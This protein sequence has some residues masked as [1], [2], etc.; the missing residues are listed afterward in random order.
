MRCHIIRS[1]SQEKEREKDVVAT[2]L[3]PN[4]NTG[5]EHV[6]KKCISAVKNSTHTTHDSVRDGESM[7]SQ[8]P[9]KG[10]TQRDSGKEQQRS[11]YRS[12]AL[13]PERVDPLIPKLGA[14]EP[15]GI[16]SFNSVNTTYPDS[17]LLLIREA[18][19]AKP[20]EQMDR[21]RKLGWKRN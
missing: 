10:D 13:T 3:N 14:V 12:N 20:T 15:A 7:Q 8:E 6:Q 4:D 11:T 5:T 1:R 17:A 2:K 18:L 9:D 19:D 21:P 16:P